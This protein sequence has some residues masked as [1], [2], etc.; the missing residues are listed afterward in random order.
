MQ[1]YSVIGSNQVPKHYNV[2]METISKLFSKEDFILR[3]RGV[4]GF[5][6]AALNGITDYNKKIIVPGLDWNKIPPDKA[7]DIAWDNVP[8]WTKLAPR[9]QK[10]KAYVVQT[11]LGHDLKSKSKFL[12][13]YTE[14]KDTIHEV[15]LAIRLAREYD[16][17][18][19]DL[20]EYSFNRLWW[21]IMEIEKE[22]A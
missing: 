9:Q 2:M 14:D 3:T 6:E 11:L 1:Y 19:F 10:Y 22:A 12:I 15:N 21:D 16:I 5:E 20:A 17:R 13:T 8:K 4:L 18:V 7:Y